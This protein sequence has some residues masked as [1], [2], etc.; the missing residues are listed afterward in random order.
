MGA[1][2]KVC[3]NCGRKMKQQFIGLLHCK[4]GM[5]WSKDSGF[6]ERTSDMV[7]ALERRKEGKKIKQVPI[8]RY[9]TDE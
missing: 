2:N 4:C 3:P 7:F 5:S 8:I 6:F 9:K 1:S